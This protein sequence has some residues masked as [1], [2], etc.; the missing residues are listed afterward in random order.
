VLL[1]TGY[2][3]S[4]FKEDFIAGLTV[5]IVALPLSMALAI[6]SGTTPDKGLITAIVAGFFI[7]LLGGSRHQIGGPTGAFVVVVFNVIHDF[8]Y[9]GLIIATAM[10]GVLLI[11]AGLLRLGTYIKYIPH[12]VVTGFTS[13]IAM[14]IFVSQINDF[15]GLKLTDIPADFIEKL[16][17]IVRHI[18]QYDSWVLFTA[19]LTLGL[20]LLFKKATPKAPAFL[21]SILLMSLC[22]WLFAIPVETI[23]SKFG[24]ISSTLPAPALPHVTLDTV[25]QLLPSAFTIAFLA[26]IESL[27]SAVVADGMSGNKHRSNCELVAQGFANIASALFT[28][29][30]ATGAIA[31]TATNI[32]SGAYSPVAG[33]IHVLVLLV[34][35][36]ILAPLCAH[37]PLACLSAILMIVAW[38][39]SEFDKFIHL[40]KAPI[41]DQF[42]LLVTFLLTVLVD[43]NLAIEVGFVLSAVLFM[44]RMA[45]AVNVQTHQDIIENDLDDFDSA[46]LPPNTPAL[47]QGVIS[48]QF[49]GPFFFGA[50]ERL[51]ETL[52][53]TGTPPNVIILQMRDV[54]FI[55][56]T[57]STALSTF[58]NQSMRSGVW[59]I[60]ACCND[61]TLQTLEKMNKASAKPNIQ[62]SNS[63]H[64][65][66]TIATKINANRP[67]QNI[68][69]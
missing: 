60:F 56:S 38:N 46:D 19:I 30:P 55:D 54:P 20:I 39:M 9:E 48:Y 1:K 12:P 21:L 69:S 5:A 66:V 65:A 37:I 43:L 14:I 52:N 23:G 49:N 2:T 18:G 29:L 62:F 32:R 36:L 7:S 50:A 58:I 47:P 44:H 11:L 34:F 68:E 3:L 40:F 15:L 16:Q 57:G 67:H 17:L 59:L 28:G 53:R 13:G 8:N 64:E 4:K 10:A 25:K 6:A 45:N 42:V 24:G 31:R 35:I 41:G 22:V 26:G 51:I 61:T 33:I 63:F 27:L